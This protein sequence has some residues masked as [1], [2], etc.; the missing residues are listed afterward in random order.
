MT[1]KEIYKYMLIE[2]N[3]VEAPSLLLEDYNY[4]IN[5]AINNY[6]NKRYNLYDTN[7][8]TT[9]DLQVLTGSVTVTINGVMTGSESGSYPVTETTHGYLF[10]LP[11]NYYH[12]LNCV[13][14]YDT[15]ED[16]KCY[17][18]GRV[19][20]FSCKRL[21]SD[22]FG[23][24]L[25]NVYLRPEYQR[26]YYYVRDRIGNTAPNIEIRAGQLSPVFA[27]NSI[28]I[29]YLKTPMLVN[30]TT[31]QVDSPVDTSQE[32]EFPDYVCQEIIKELTVLVMEN[33]SDPRLQTNPM[34][35]QS[36]P[37]NREQ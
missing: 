22:M 6:V 28:T 7:Q 3:K 14:Y 21:T 4:F 13:V 1:A 15:K 26:P 34:V 10:P 12:L 31:E 2:Q 24:I 27:L 5:K 30:L 9:D 25:N 29:D 11:K 32:M 8:Q 17:P 23:F 35:N 18:K 36:I 20:S 16:Y 37:Q 19:H 33:A